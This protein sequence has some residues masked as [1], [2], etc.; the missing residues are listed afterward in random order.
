MKSDNDQKEIPV[1]IR[2]PDYRLR[3]FVSST[4]KELAKE[5]EAAKEAIQHLRLVPVMFESGARSHPS[6]D[7]Y[8]AYLEQSHLFIGIYWKSYGWVPPG[9]EISGLED[10]FILSKNLPRLIYIKDQKAE[11]EGGLQNMLNRIKN[12]GM[13]SYK[14][15]SDA[16]EL[17]GII[18]NDL[19]LLL[20]EHFET[21]RGSRTAQEQR[22]TNVPTPRNPLIGRE[23][24]LTFVREMLKRRDVGMVTLVG[25]GGTGKSRLGLQVALNMLDDFH[26][27][28]YLVRLTPVHDPALVISTIADTLGIRET[29]DEKS[30][31]GKLKEFLREKHMLLLLDNFEQ[32][33][34]AAPKVAELMEACPDVRFVV[35][36]RAPLKVRS[37]RELFVQPLTAPAHHA[38]IDLK[39]VSQYEAVELFIQRAKSINPGFAVTDENAPAVAEICHR[40]DG[41]PLAIELAAARIRMLTPQD[42]LARLEKRLDLLKG[43]VRDLPERQQTLRSAI[44]WSYELL[45]ENAKKLFRRLSVFV[46]GWTLEAAESVC[47][48]DG[49]LG[50]DLMDEMESLVDNSL[51]KR[52]QDESDDEICFNMLETIREYADEKLVEHRE[53]EQARLQHALYFQ[54]FVHDLEPRVRSRER[55]KATRR[56][57]REFGNI[58]AILEFAS[59]HGENIEIAQEIGVALAWFWQSSMSITES[60]SW[61][62]RLLARV[63][64][65]TPLSLHAGLLWGIGGFAWS[66][67]DLKTAVTSLEES[68]RLCRE[69][70][71]ERLLAN[72]LIVHGL[73]A[74]SAGDIQTAT[75]AYT[76][77]IQLS[78][79]FGEK[80]S[81][82][83]ALSW[84]GD[85]ALL[86]ND[87]EGCRELHEQAI[88]L[89]RVQ[90]DPW[91]L[92]SPLMADGNTALVAETPEK[93]ESI[94]TEAISL[95]KEIDDKWSLAWALCG[96]GHAALQLHK[97]ELARPNLEE[98]FA[99]ARNIGNPGA[100]IAA[101][102]GA[103]IY[104]ASPFEGKPASDNPAPSVLN[105]IRLLGAIP[106]LNVKAHMYYWAGWNA[107]YQRALANARQ[108]TV[109]TLWEK[110]FAEGMSL[111]MQEAVGIALHELNAK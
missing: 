83:L 31:P 69:A 28:V 40:L 30:L 93:A 50:A 55:V 9:G 98:C 84:M 72:I 67:G 101:L 70:K 38:Q 96:L 109:D 1:V 39:D 16:E 108:L 56:L 15:F 60:R 71:D 17:R 77:S 66:Q 24:E 47:N 11:R 87:L 20:T 106:P 80:W 26:D 61:A 90:G 104:A 58:R 111:S 91:I 34:E 23:A 25:P 57:R 81:E 8:R 29:Q 78:R 32:V 4:L 107:L 100:T 14:Y 54:E 41:L 63:G 22:L 7:L 2:P 65:A 36:S 5:R 48:F 42:L 59:D 10:E 46:G 105:T 76:E 99:V 79:K 13:T 64:E 75:A 88:A 94:Y 6:Q 18:E 19:A 102:I 12:E 103:A 73:A 92:F 110:A 53:L 51:L 86:Q 43:G 85:V 27:G 33:L 68:V 89:A 21:A 35:T 45:D 3:V 74:T 82:S 52:R 44:G 37:E 95:L 97:P 49:D 62:E